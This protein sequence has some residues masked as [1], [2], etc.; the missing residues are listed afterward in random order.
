MNLS[1]KEINE[2]IYSLGITYHNGNFVNKD[3]KSFY[4]GARL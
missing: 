1:I 3:L 4:I 2:L